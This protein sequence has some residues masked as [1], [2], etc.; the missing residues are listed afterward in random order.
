ME[1]IMLNQ[2]QSLLNFVIFK[3]ENA[4]C[5]EFLQV[6]KEGNREAQKQPNFTKLST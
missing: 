1:A 5:K 3:I 6:Q 2:L 4:T